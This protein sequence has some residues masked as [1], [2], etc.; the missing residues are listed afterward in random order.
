MGFIVCFLSE[1][2]CLV[3]L[4]RSQ[5]ALDTTVVIW[6]QQEHKE[7]ISR[8]ERCIPE[9]SDIREGFYFFIHSKC[10]KVLYN[11]SNSKQY[12]ILTQQYIIYI[13]DRPTHFYIKYIIFQISQLN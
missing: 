5:K 12:K 8:G 2:Q 4:L 7:R 1:F 11:G 9:K 3:S 10:L 13:K 6:N